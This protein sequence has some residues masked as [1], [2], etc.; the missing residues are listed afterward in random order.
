MAEI[1]VSLF[2]GQ[3]DAALRDPA[4]LIRANLECVEAAIAGIEHS[5]EITR[6]RM[7]QGKRAFDEGTLTTREQRLVQFQELRATLE[8]VLSDE[9]LTAAV[10]RRRGEIRR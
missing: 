2:E 1:Q 7:A 9:R 5:I 10:A 4:A 8:A 6:G 3:S